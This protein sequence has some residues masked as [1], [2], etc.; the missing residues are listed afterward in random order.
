M[1]RSSL[2]SALHARRLDAAVMR[3]IVLLA[4]PSQ[5]RALA[6]HVPRLCNL[7]Q[8]RPPLSRRHVNAHAG[9]G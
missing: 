8:R 9:R 3:G 7:T 5:A 6:A 2:Q 4:C 1:L